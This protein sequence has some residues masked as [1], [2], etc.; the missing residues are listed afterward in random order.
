SSI[1][2]P[3]YSVDANYIIFRDI[4][5]TDDG[6][7][8]GETQEWNPIENLTGIMEG[9]LNMEEGVNATIHNLEI[10]QDSAIDQSVKGGI[11]GTLFNTETNTEYG[12]GLFRDLVTEYDKDLSFNDKVISVS[13]ITL[14]NVTV[15]TTTDRI[16]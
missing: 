6:T 8:D 3:I 10:N 5:L 4:Y 2:S 12:V 9:R 16:D 1:G 15:K 11:I 13:N 14:N 7:A